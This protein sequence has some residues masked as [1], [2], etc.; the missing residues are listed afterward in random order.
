MLPLFQILYARMVLVVLCALCLKQNI[1]TC[2]LLFAFVILYVRIL[3]LSNIMCARLCGPGISLEYL[4]CIIHNT[5][6][7]DAISFSH[8]SCTL[9]SYNTSSCSSNA[10]DNVGKHMESNRQWGRSVNKED[11]LG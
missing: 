7:L 2:E 6:L 10:R 8:T 11:H 9:I 5:A 4:Y 1:E 3:G